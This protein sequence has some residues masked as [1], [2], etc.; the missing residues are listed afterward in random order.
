MSQLSIQIESKTTALVVRLQG[1]AGAVNAAALD[2]QVR[3]IIVN[4]PGL[5]VVDLAGVTFISSTA[6]GLLAHLQRRIEEVGGRLYLAGPTTQVRE[7][8]ERC[9]IGDLLPMVESVDSAFH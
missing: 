8:I 6:V 4:R 1:H 2:R 5:V 9:R 7:V 3:E